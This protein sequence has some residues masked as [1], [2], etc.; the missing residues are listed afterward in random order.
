MVF[1]FETHAAHIL[2]EA[3][4]TLSL[5]V[6]EIHVPNDQLWMGYSI[7]PRGIACCEI[8]V[9]LPAFSQSEVDDKKSMLAIDDPR[10]DHRTEHSPYVLEYPN[11][12]S[13]YRVPITTPL[14]VNIGMRILNAIC[15]T[16]TDSRWAP[17]AS[18]MIGHGMAYRPMKCDSYKRHR[19]RL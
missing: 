2:A 13:Y 15:R 14:S 7:I 1:T 17:T 16:I 10:K 8:T 18:W 19:R 5:E 4:R 11:T 12:R 6:D 3:T 9:N